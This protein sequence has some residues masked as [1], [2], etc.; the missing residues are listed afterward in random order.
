MPDQPTVDP[1]ERRKHTRHDISATAQ[2]YYDPAR[3]LTVDIV[4]LS[5]EGFCVEC[6]RAALEHMLPAIPSSDSVD[7]IP[8]RLSFELESSVR[9]LASSVYLKPI[10]G[11]RCQMGLELVDVELGVLE[12]SEYIAGL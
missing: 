11:D 10:A 2:L 12:L 7:K 8:L 3:S 6:E 1:A 5:Y 4:D 9:V